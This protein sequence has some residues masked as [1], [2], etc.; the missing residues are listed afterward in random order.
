MNFAR[1]FIPLTLVAALLT[2]CA[3]DGM[4]TKQTGGA[5]L[6]GVGGAL[7]GAQFGSGRGQLAATALGTL[8]G[9]YVG[10]EV[11]RSLDAA[12]RQAAMAAQQRAYTAPMRETIAWNN[13]NSGNSGTF[14]PV[15]DGTSSTGAYCREY[16]T[17]ITVGGQTEQGYG[18]ACRQPD[19]SWK[20]VQ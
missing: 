2:G 1:K 9:A 4:G 18:T 6:G 19:G 10:S 20:I 15:R 3:T 11:G 16:Q 14:T 12:D 13:P 17:T 7:A 8:I 5:V